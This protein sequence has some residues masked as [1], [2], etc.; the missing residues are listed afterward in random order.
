M[1]RHQVVHELF[2]EYVIKNNVSCGE[3]KADASTAG[4]TLEC[5]LYKGVSKERAKAGIEYFL[6]N[7]WGAFNLKF[8][9]KN[10]SKP[11]QFWVR[12]FSTSL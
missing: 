3:L 2:M 4:W 10:G 6:V 9:Q 8:F 1:E 7:A 5:Q 12:F 11:G